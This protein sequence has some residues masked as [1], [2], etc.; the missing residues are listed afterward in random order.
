MGVRTKKKKK[1]YAE[2]GLL[3]GQ[4]SAADGQHVDQDHDQ[5]R[6]N[7]REEAQEDEPEHGQDD[8]AYAVM[9][10]VFQLFFFFF[11]LVQCCQMVRLFLCS[12]FKT[13]PPTQSFFQS[14]IFYKIHE[15]HILFIKVQLN[16]EV[17]CSIHEVLE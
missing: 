3:W 4:D 7:A 2:P 12:F 5:P 11:F 8:A 16:S 15:G 1:T 17:Q 10:I 13:I 14:V 9:S 6:D